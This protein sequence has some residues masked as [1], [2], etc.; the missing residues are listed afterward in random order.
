VLLCENVFHCIANIYIDD[1]TESCHLPVVAIFYS[2]VACDNVTPTV[3]GSRDHVNYVFNDTTITSLNDSLLS[4]FNNSKLKDLMCVIS[5]VSLDINCIVHDLSYTFVQCLKVCE[6]RYT[7]TDAPY[8]RSPWF[9]KEC[10]KL[11]SR[12]LVCLRNFRSEKTDASFEQNIVAKRVF[13]E[14]C[15][16]K[17]INYYNRKLDEL[18]SNVRWPRSFWAK[19]KSLHGQ[20]NSSNF[21]TTEDWFKHFS[22]LFNDD[23]TNDVLEPD[24][25]DAYY[26]ITV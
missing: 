11:K 23:S 20:H 26:V 5:N 2:N 25:D 12:K 7:R 9:D 15:Y 24:A 8:N 18:V 16:S 21:I 22:S 3:K 6:K 13:K 10:R 4:W 17:R 1:R 19:I 14:L